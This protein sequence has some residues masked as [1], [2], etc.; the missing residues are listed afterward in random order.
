VKS[1]EREANSGEPNTAPRF[2]LLAPCCMADEPRGEREDFV[3]APASARGAQ[4][5]LH[6]F[7]GEAGAVEA[8]VVEHARGQKPL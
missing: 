3:G 8:G 5:L 1:R 6:P 4:E 7:H 2:L